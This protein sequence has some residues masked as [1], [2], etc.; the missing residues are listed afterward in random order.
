MRRPRPDFWRDTPITAT[1]CGAKSGV[2]RSDMPD[3]CF[4]TAATAGPALT[5]GHDTVHA[6]PCGILA[7]VWHFFGTAGCGPG[8]PVEKVAAGCVARVVP[9]RCPEAPVIDLKNVLVATDFGDA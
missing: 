7:T 9:K 5:D 8:P 6:A 4:K 3:C 2:S 1:A